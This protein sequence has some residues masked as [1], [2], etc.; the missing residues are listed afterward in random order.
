MNK[1]IGALGSASFV[2]ANA[3]SAFADEMRGLRLGPSPSHG[4]P[5]PEI[6]ASAV[7]LLLAGVVV[8]YVIK[9][10]RS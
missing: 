9:R 4:A 1:L 3:A 2:V 10:R 6:G 7:G 8:M 5:A